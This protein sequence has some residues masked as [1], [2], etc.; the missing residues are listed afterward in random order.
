MPKTFFKAVRMDRT[1]H[2]DKKT[3]W[4]KGNPI[5]VDNAVQGGSC[6]VGLHASPRLLDTLQYQGSDSVYCEVELV[7]ILGSDGT[8]SRA[9]GAR[10]LKW[11]GRA[12]TNR[13]AGFDLWAI[14]HPFHPWSIKAKKRQTKTLE[15]LGRAW[16]EVRKSSYWSALQTY[17]NNKKLNVGT[18]SGIAMKRLAGIENQEVTGFVASAFAG[19]DIDFKDAPEGFRNAPW[20]PLMFL[21]NAGYVPTYQGGGYG[22][23]PTKC[24]IKSGK[25]GK[26]HYSF[27]I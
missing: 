17:G 18:L 2:R 23:T 24:V 14:N 9:K 26:D 27:N 11:L 4:Q 1:S 6:G 21:W 19:C 8:K 25:D 15:R 5:F 13:I 12:D 22:C 20:Q 3:T 7:E 16:L 10:V